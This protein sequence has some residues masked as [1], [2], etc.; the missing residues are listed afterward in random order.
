MPA[1]SSNIEVTLQNIKEQ[2][3]CFLKK[4]SEKY[5]E[6]M[7][8]NTVFAGPI[9]LKAI[10][11]ILSSEIIVHYYILNSNAPS[12]Y[13]ATNDIHI[14]FKDK[15][16]YQAILKKFNGDYKLS[17]TK[18]NANCLFTA[19]IEAAIAAD[20]AVSI[21]YSEHY[22]SIGA[23]NLRQD[24]C[25]VISKD[26]AEMTSIKKLFKSLVWAKDQETIKYYKNKLPDM[27]LRKRAVD[28]AKQRLA[29]EKPKQNIIYCNSL[30]KR[31]TIM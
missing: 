23:N 22:A 11:K 10:R 8:N 29:A 5:I 27:F 7:K 17:K 31:C 21:H 24:V 14:L 3:D 2:T 26:L 18:I 30:Y 25:C 1:K 6:T 16:T 13:S 9:E 12:F 4:I 20:V 19:C 15:N 28:L